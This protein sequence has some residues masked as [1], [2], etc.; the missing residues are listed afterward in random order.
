M[1]GPT[2]KLIHYSLSKYDKDQPLRTPI[3][4]NVAYSFDS[5]EEI[6]DAFA[7]KTGQHMYAR[8]TSPT[9]APA[10][11]KLKNFTS[12]AHCLFT[13][14]GVAAIHCALLTIL[15]TGDNLIASPH[16]F[17]HT[18]SLF[19]DTFHDM[20]I[21]VRFADMR[22]PESIKSHIDENTRGVF[23]ENITNP[24]LFVHD[25]EDIS[26]ICRNAGILLL[27][28]NTIMTPYLFNSREWG[29]DIE[30]LSTT[31]S[32]SGGGTTVGGAVMFYDS[33]AWNNH[34]R[35][36]Q[37]DSLR[38][39]DAAIQ[40]MRKQIFRNTGPTLSPFNAYLIDL[41]METLPLRIDR[42]C[43]NAQQI[44]HY[45]EHHQ[46]IKKVIYP[47]LRNNPFFDHVQKYYKGNGGPVV[48]F[49]LESKEACYSFMN[50][51]KMISRATNLGD[52]KSLIIHP[53]STIYGGYNQQERK[54]MEI[55]DELIRLSVGLEDPEDLKE[56]IEQALKFINH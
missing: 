2:S 8:T 5:A 4:A 46:N 10:E 53:A 35:F 38:P 22:N 51:L 52:N 12:A 17:G 33:P 13:S 18:Y 30:I 39:L 42:Y 45:T 6:E 9:L 21:E 56:D 54:E 50:Q 23:V 15:R 44:A 25:I 36:K 28:D 14:S 55:S 41:G 20:G 11:E 16:L 34:P 7:G 1:K 27:A 19:K 24:Q 32:F 31:K 47:G 43:D 48:C 37:D 26:N 3:F 29:V 49:E 40:K